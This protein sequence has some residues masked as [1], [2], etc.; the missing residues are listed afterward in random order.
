MKRNGAALALVFVFMY[1]PGLVFAYHVLNNSSGGGFVFIKWDNLPVNFRVDGGTLQGGDGIAIIEGACNQWNGVPTARGLCGA[2]TVL[3][4]DITA[5]NFDALPLQD[6]TII[7]FDETGDIL[8][9]LGFS[10][11]TLGLG[12]TFSNT[13]TGEITDALLILNGSIPSS[14]TADLLSTAVH[15]LG[16]VWGLAHTAVGGINSANTTPGLEAINPSAIPTMFP[17][18]IPVNDAFGRTLE[19]D[20]LAG[21]SV[22][23]PQG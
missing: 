22:L 16:H 2:L 1:I 9:S 6:D 17:F 13:T 7:I 21:I 18:N 15:E 3:P 12:I 14:K 4:M 23:Y 11:N 19:E 10:A 5:A 8:S 20:D